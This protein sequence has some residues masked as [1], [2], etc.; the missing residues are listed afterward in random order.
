MRCQR[1]PDDDGAVS[2]ANNLVAAG[3]VGATSVVTIADANV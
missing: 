1:K 2:L 3:R